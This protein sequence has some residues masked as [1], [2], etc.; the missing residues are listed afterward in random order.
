MDEL[1]TMNAILN[2]TSTALLLAGYGLIRRKKVT[3]HRA[4]MITAFVV[5]M[6]F[7]VGYVLHKW[8]LFETTGSYNT[9]FQGTG[10][11]RTLYFSILIPHVILAALIPFLASVT[12]FRGW[13]MDVV[14]HRKLARITLPIWLF[15]SVTGVIVYFMLYQWFPA[16]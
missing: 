8:H 4:V 16:S 7:L 14:K 2:G 15:V 3:Q 9:V 1:P 12:L 13:K 6:L 11:W 10:A 5:S